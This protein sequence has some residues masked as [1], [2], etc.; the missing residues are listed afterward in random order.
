MIIEI[1][2]SILFNRRASL[3]VDP[4]ISTFARSI[5]RS[6]QRCLLHPSQVV[7]VFPALP[8][9][10][11]KDSDILIKYPSYGCEVSPFFSRRCS[12][13]AILRKILTELQ[14]HYSSSL[15][16]SGGLISSFDVDHISFLISNAFSC[17]C[18]S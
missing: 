12:Y 2:M 13:P 14:V 9:L 17:W 8:P 6:L 18:T 3:Q 11:F 1:V 15:F 16:F 5:L 7:F 10:F 4:I